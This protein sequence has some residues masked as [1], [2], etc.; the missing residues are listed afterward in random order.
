[1]LIMFTDFI[2]DIEYRYNLGFKAVAVIILVIFLNIALVFIELGLQSRKSYLK[3]KRAKKWKDHDI[4]D[5]KLADFI[6]RDLYVNTRKNNVS[7]SFR[8]GQVKF[9][10]DNYT[11]KEKSVKVKLIFEE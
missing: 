9:M 1:M 2:P 6:I 4:M 7:Q 11:F 8:D 3:R 10:M 5:Q